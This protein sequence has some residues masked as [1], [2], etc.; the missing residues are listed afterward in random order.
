MI[1]K[2]PR[3]FIDWSLFS[4]LIARATPKE[5]EEMKAKIEAEIALVKKAWGDLSMRELRF[6]EIEKLGLSR[7][8]ENRNTPLFIMGFTEFDR[9]GDVPYEVVE[10]LTDKRKLILK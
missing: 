5:L 2:R 1:V 8:Q 6:S 3:R 7:Y 4:M 10:V 9:K